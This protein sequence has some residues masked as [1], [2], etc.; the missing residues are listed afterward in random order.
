MPVY[1]IINYFLG[2]NINENNSMKEEDI[3]NEEFG[4][5]F[6]IPSNF[7][8]IESNISSTTHSNSTSEP[9]NLTDIE[10]TTSQIE[11]TP[12][13]L[14]DLPMTPKKLNPSAFTHS[15]PNSSLCNNKPAILKPNVL[16][17]KSPEFLNSDTTEKGMDCSNVTFNNENRDITIINNEDKY[18]KITNIE[19][20][21]DAITNTEDKYDDVTTNEDKYEDATNNENKDTDITNDE[22]NYGDAANKEDNYEDISNNERTYKSDNRILRGTDLNKQDAFKDET[23]NY[24]QFSTK[25]GKEEGAMNQNISDTQMLCLMK[26]PSNMWNDIKTKT[27]SIRLNSEEH[28]RNKIENI[29]K[30]NHPKTR[31]I[32]NKISPL[33]N[34]FEG[35]VINCNISSHFESQEHTFIV[36]VQIT[37]AKSES[38][39]SV[40]CISMPNWKLNENIPTN[41]FTSL[42]NNGK[43][44]PQIDLNNSALLN[45]KVHILEERIKQL[46]KFDSRRLMMRKEITTLK[47]SK[48]ELNANLKKL[49]EEK[50]AYKSKYE[51]SQD[52]LKSVNN[53]LYHLKR[54]NENTEEKLKNILLENKILTD[55]LELLE[56]DK[57]TYSKELQMI[58]SKLKINNKELSAYKEKVVNF[59]SYLPKLVNII[60]NQHKIFSVK[61]KEIRKLVEKNKLKAYESEVQKTTLTTE[62]RNVENQLSSS[63]IIILHLKR[64][65]KSQSEELK[66]LKKE[67]SNYKQ[68]NSELIQ[69]KVQLTNVIKIAYN[70]LR[71][72]ELYDKPI[73]DKLI[74]DDN[75]PM[76]F[77]KKLSQIKNSDFNDMFSKLYKTSGFITEDIEEMKVSFPKISDMSKKVITSLNSLLENQNAHLERIENLAASTDIFNTE[78][79]ST[80]KLLTDIKKENEVS[81]TKRINFQDKLLKTETQNEIN[82]KSLL[83]KKDNCN[84]ELTEQ[85]SSCLKYMSDMEHT[86]QNEISR[87]GILQSILVVKET[88]VEAL[89]NKLNAQSEN[90]NELTKKLEKLT[91]DKS[92]RI[93]E[94][95]IRNTFK[96]DGSNSLIEN[97]KLDQVDELTMIQLQNALKNIIV[98]LKIPFDKFSY[99]MPLITIYIHL[100][101]VIFLKFIN[102]IH[103]KL[104][105][106]YFEMERFTTEA[107]VQFMN[108]HDLNTVKHPIATYL[109]SMLKELENKIEDQ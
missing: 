31:H 1:T 97:L 38:N 11:E 81:E 62:V 98:S 33:I 68:Q 32:G 47:T 49:E 3:R 70:F 93:T 100:E 51:K 108:T 77:I 25:I 48:R 9:G 73:F 8:P 44:L 35:N 80:K 23:P 4:N 53:E 64:N 84:E 52:I 96:G 46:D 83:L 99:K 101:R 60:Q 26:E 5:S 22:D 95:N 94:N 72:F 39:Q 42:P 37:S 102:R 89:N 54:Q 21:C 86:M 85:L 43:M 55:R 14:Q 106:R 92:L 56:K 6:Q 82:L 13:Y 12:N 57:L 71:S 50:N 30:C 17:F 16:K 34:Q 87:I 19:D 107:Y 91:G 36:P 41:L 76:I 10:S 7:D 109:H 40:Y 61:S 45:E 63:R 79:S 18:E 24:P 58:S 74:Q 15:R 88:E 20:K 2:T 69:N 65:C 103:F 75:D 78:I 67:T 29:K 90:I 59:K 104:H 105:D 27:N 28:S 66:E